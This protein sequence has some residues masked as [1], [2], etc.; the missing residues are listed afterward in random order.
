MGVQFYRQKSLMDY[1]V[2]FYAP[3]AR[4]VI[5][6]GGSQHMSQ[7]GSD[8][9]RS[10]DADLKRQGLTVLRLNDLEVLQQTDAVVQSVYGVV[11]RSLLDE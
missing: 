10:R 8:R 7:R 5:E 6:V 1:I 9:D 3:S 11:E 4:L 2:D